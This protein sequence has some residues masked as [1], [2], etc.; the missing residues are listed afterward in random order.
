[1]KFWV[2]QQ[3]PL[4]QAALVD[5]GKVMREIPL[6][7]PQ[8][9]AR[10]VDVIG[11]CG[12]DLGVLQTASLEL[13]TRDG[14]QCLKHFYSPLIHEPHSI[15]LW[16]KNEFLILSTGLELF[17]TMDMEG[18]ITWEFW[19]YKHGIGGRNEYF[20]RDDWASRQLSGLQYMP[21]PSKA[22]HFNSVFRVEDRILTSALKTGK[23][24]EIKPHSDW[25]K[26]IYQTECHGV[27]SPIYTSDGIL[28]GT[29]KGLVL[30]DG[31]REHYF[32]ED[33]NWPKYLRQLEDGR[34]AV[35]HEA[36]LSIL[37]KN[38]HQD[39]FFPLPRPFHFA[40]LEE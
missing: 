34:Y 15:S 10:R 30:F 39:A 24:Y 5:D 4:F 33:I 25:F 16:N 13:W 7:S 26:E 1:M 9:V 22:S 31:S 19:A 18:N 29:E 3:R 6:R 35:T 36:G 32:A 8:T 14:L 40:F 11:E 2:A 23:I 37:D 38:F 21:F 28:F 17:F 12:N 20:D 27:H